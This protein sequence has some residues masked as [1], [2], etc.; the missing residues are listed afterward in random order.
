MDKSYAVVEGGIVTNVIVWDGDE[1]NWT[2]P[3]GATM[4]LVEDGM[5][6]HIG[7]GYANGVF[8]QPEPPVLTP[9]QILAGNTATRDALLSTAA[10]AIAPLQDA[11]DLD[12]ATPEETA[13]LKLWKQYRVAVNR[14]DLTK[15]NP[16]WP[17]APAA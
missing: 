10:L 1:T 17:T 15:E 4:V 11:V 14:M 16:V 3:E 12:E 7:L 6:P 5:V 9:D 8:E 2:P 13:L